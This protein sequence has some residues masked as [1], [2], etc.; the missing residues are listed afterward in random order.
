[1]KTAVW[2]KRLS[3]LAACLFCIF[4]SCAAQSRKAMPPALYSL[5]QPQQAIDLPKHI[6]EISGVAY[7]NGSLYAIDDDKGNLYKISVAEK[8]QVQQWEVGK[9]QDFEDIARANGTIYI[10]SS[11]G[12]LLFFPEKFPPEKVEHADL[13]LKGKNEFE[14][15]YFD[16]SNNRL[17]MLCKDCHKDGK[18]I[19]TAYA[20]NVATKSFEK[21]PAFEINRRDIESVLGKTVAKF[22]PSAGAVHPL[23]GEIY[24]LSSI[25]QLL[26]VLDKRYQVAAVYTLNKKLFKQPEGLT[27]TP[28]GDMIISN[29]YAGSGAA[30]LLYF[31]MKR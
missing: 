19:T 1:M 8:P 22:K 28:Q 11:K 5:D 7:E 18:H 17:I 24:V 26:V 10:L 16:A 27:F 2:N 23:T 15:L 31:K 12:R 25:N 6:N 29:E 4:S 9:P 3:G 30:N 13:E 20:F 21:K 14:T